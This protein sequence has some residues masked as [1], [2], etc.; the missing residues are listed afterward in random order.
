MHVTIPKLFLIV[1]KMDFSLGFI[2]FPAYNDTICCY[3][4]YDSIFAVRRNEEL[5]I[6]WDICEVQI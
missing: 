2:L 5:K 1:L 4:L 3:F 6:D